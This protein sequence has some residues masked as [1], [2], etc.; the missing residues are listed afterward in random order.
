MERGGE[1]AQWERR[2]N[3]EFEDAYGVLFPRRSGASLS[4][5]SGA[6]IHRAGQARLVSESERS[7]WVGENCTYIEVRGVGGAEQRRGPST[8]SLELVVY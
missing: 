1:R 6:A 5:H 3:P 8:Y 4:W 2:G 7:D